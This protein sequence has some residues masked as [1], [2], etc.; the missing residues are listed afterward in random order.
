MK[1]LVLEEDLGALLPLEEDEQAV[2]CCLNS[3]EP[4]LYIATSH[5]DVLC[6]SLETFKVEWRQSISTVAGG[7]DSAVTGFCFSL[8]LEAICISLS[9]GELL[10]LN[11]DTQ[12]LEEVGA[13]EGGIVALQWSPDGEVLAVISGMGN[14]LLMDQEW[15]LLAEVHLA[16][17]PPGCP[18]PGSWFRDIQLSWRGDGKFFATSHRAL[19]DGTPQ[20][21]MLVWDRTA[22]CQLHATCEEA[23]GLLPVLAWQPNGRHLYTVQQQSAVA[24]SSKPPGSAG[25]AAK[26]AA[27]RAGA[28]PPQQQLAGQ[29]GVKGSE[30]TA[31]A[32][33][34]QHQQ[35]Q[36]QQ[37]LAPPKLLPP[38]PRV[39]LYERNGLGHGGFPLRARG[40]VVAMEWS[41]DSELLAVV[42]AVEGQGCTGDSLQRQPQRPDQQEQQ[43]AHATLAQQWHS[44]EQGGGQREW[45]L[46]IWHRSNWHWYLKLERRY[47]VQQQQLQQQQQEQQDESVECSSSWGVAPLVLWDDKQA[48]R[49]HVVVP[50]GRGMQCGAAY[51]Q[52]QVL[53]DAHSVVPPPMSAARAVLPSPV[54]ALAVSSSTQ[55]PDEAVAV[56]M[57]DGRL[58]LLR[59]CEEDLWEET[60]EEELDARAAV[61]RTHP[62]HSL[63]GADDVLVGCGDAYVGSSTEDALQPMLAP[64]EHWPLQGKPRVRALCWLGED[65][66]LA[67]QAAWS[68]QGGASAGIREEQQQGPGSRGGYG[69]GVSVGA[70]CDSS[71]G[72]SGYGGDVL[73]E[74]Q[75]L[76]PSS[77]SMDVQGGQQDHHHQQQQQHQQQQSQFG[78]GVRVAA[79]PVCTSPGTRVLRVVPHA[80]GGAVVAMASGEVRHYIPSSGSSLSHPGGSARLLSLGQACSFPAACPWVVPVPPLEHLGQASASFSPALGLCRA[81]YLYW[82]AMLVAP[83]VTSLTTR[84]GGPG[85]PALLFCSRRSLMYTVFLA[86]LGVPGGYAHKELTEASGLGLPTERKQLEV[87]EYRSAV[88]QGMRPN[89]ATAAARNVLVRSVEQGS[90]LL[91]APKDGVRVVMQM[92][93]G[94]LEAVAP[95]MLVLAAIADALQ[96]RAYAAAWELATTNRVDLNLLVDWNWPAFLYDVPAFVA[97][98][99]APSDLTDLLFAL[100]PGNM[101][102][103]GGLYAG[104]PIKPCGQHYAAAAAGAPNAEGGEP[105]TQREEGSLEGGLS[106]EQ[107]EQALRAGKVNA[108]CMAMR[109]AVEARMRRQAA[110]DSAA[111]EGPRVAADGVSTA[112]PGST[113]AAAQQLLTVLVTTFSRSQPPQLGQALSAIKDAKEAA[114]AKDGASGQQGPAEQAL[115]A[116][117]LHVDADA[118]YQAALG[119][120]ELPLAF[121]VITHAQRDPGEYAL[122]LQRFAEVQDP[123]MRRYTIDMHLRRFNLALGHLVAADRDA[124]FEQALALAK[125]HNLLRQLL[126]LYNEDPVRRRVVLR[127][128]GEALEASNKMEDAGVAYVAAGALQDGLRAYRHSLFPLPNSGSPEE[129][130]SLVVHVMSLAPPEATLTHTGALAE[131]LVILEHEQDARTLQTAVSEWIAAHQD[132]AEDI[133]QNPFPED[134]VPHAYQQI[135]ELQRRPGKPAPEVAWKWDI[136]RVAT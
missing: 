67:V 21:V 12:Q 98:V 86:Q 75:V 51:E 23:E 28:Q 91:A 58:A 118:A 54:A 129:E 13:V 9:T 94:N 47:S 82:G 68:A 39:L 80:A 59:S 65:R 93:R 133:Y 115:R 111:A 44:Q 3:T 123:H 87:S 52:M 135:L 71:S 76:R 31:P 105:L 88:H 6:L 16:D 127:A 66:L 92:P 116:M 34:H 40:R 5:C 10:L 48:S 107:V 36:Q 77:D 106:R 119:L 1:N 61:A 45:Q 2:K 35:Q 33:V 110:G 121:M 20:R 102:H 117:L 95:R 79:A 136:L 4:R 11:V 19:R 96:A 73:V 70:R 85:G 125:Q 25:L 122:E 90:H 37:A 46:Q 57:S 74:L 69:G 63:Q 81:G 60:L 15:E 30:K 128:C 104:I 38:P 29:E 130:A 83:D 55:A 126:A 100:R 24:H 131:L 50:R 53:W 49:L 27:L 112:L 120:Y 18:N 78:V 99:P 26:R 14:I 89:A 109:A 84:T 32:G 132:A 72:G 113:H 114:L 42:Q 43:E 124:H 7:P 97:A 108:V 17:P 103:E 62:A 22:S 134:R 64:V 41:S 101:C 56:A 8:E